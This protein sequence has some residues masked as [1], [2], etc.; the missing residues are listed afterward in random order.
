MHNPSKTRKKLNRS[1]VLAVLLCVF[2][3]A[4]TYAL[5]YA[6]VTVDDNRF[7]TGEVH[8]DL[9]GGMPVIEEHEY[10]FEPGMTVEKPFYIQNESTW[11]VYY[12]LYFD[13]VE[14]GLADILEITIYEPMPDNEQKVLYQGTAASLSRQNVIAAD[15]ILLLGERR[16]LMVQFYYPEQSGNATQNRQLKFDLCA[17][18]VQEK[19][20]PDKAFD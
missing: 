16:D 7:K 11:A 4:T 10:L 6:T 20:N 19:N 2:L 8:I 17:D 3:C 9:N 13:H 18:A 1:I 5:N 12:K 14:G 15:D